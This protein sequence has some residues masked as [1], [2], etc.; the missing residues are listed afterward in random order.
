[1]DGIFVLILQDNGW[2]A[3]VDLSPAVSAFHY[4]TGQTEIPAEGLGLTMGLL[5]DAVPQI[6]L[7]RGWNSS[8]KW[9]SQLFDSITAPSFEGLWDTV[10]QSRQ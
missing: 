8:C 5:G 9:M 3:K 1:M 7:Q 10:E 4:P 6:L 2:V